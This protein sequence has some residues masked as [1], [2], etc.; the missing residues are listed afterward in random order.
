[1]IN[2]LVCKIPPWFIFL[3][4]SVY[5]HSLHRQWM[6]NTNSDSIFIQTVEKHVSHYQNYCLNEPVNENKMNDMKVKCPLSL[7]CRR[8]TK[9]KPGQST[10]SRVCLLKKR[11]DKSTFYQRSGVPRCRPQ[12]LLCWQISLLNDFPFLKSDKKTLILL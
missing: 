6:A 7:T 5:H 2:W 4:I 1:M 3:S 10:L 9:G 12:W 11:P 8:L